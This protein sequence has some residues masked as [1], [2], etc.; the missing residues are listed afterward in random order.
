[1]SNLHFK[2]SA[3]FP[4][5]WIFFVAIRMSLHISV[6]VLFLRQTLLKKN[7]QKKDKRWGEDQ[8]KTNRKRNQ[9]SLKWQHVLQVDWF[10]D[11]DLVLS[12]HHLG[13][14]AWLKG[15]TSQ[16]VSNIKAFV[17]HHVNL[18]GVRMVPA[19]TARTNV[20]A[21]YESG[22]SV[23]QAHLC[24]HPKWLIKNKV[25]FGITGLIAHYPEQANLKSGSCMSRRVPSFTNAPSAFMPP[26]VYVVFGRHPNLCR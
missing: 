5:I 25:T 4:V 17:G 23:L 22:V 19:A 21:G 11:I 14:D 2:N 6:L 16:W 9:V 1:M 26:P 15:W 12:A 10:M 3:Q 13:A 24:I 8:V 18:G 7:K 20:R